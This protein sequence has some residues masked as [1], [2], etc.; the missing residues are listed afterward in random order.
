MIQLRFTSNKA[1]DESFLAICDVKIREFYEFYCSKKQGRKM[2]SRHDFDPVKMTR[3]LPSIT[4][5]DAESGDYRYRLVGTKEVEVRG[6]DPTGK[7]VKEAFYG[8]LL[9]E[10]EENYNYVCQSKSFI[11]DHNNETEDPNQI[12]YDETLFLPLSN[13]DITVNIVM[14][15]SVQQ[16][17]SGR[18][19]F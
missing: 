2:P 6:N 5:V 14:L 9:E 16:F 3:F 13:D 1:Y 17:K 15:F 7:T 10:V 11:Y 12:L 8:S 18:G 19:S 4:L